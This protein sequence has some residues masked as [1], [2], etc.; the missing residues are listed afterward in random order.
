[1]LL[2]LMCILGQIIDLHHL[3]HHP[4]VERESSSAVIQVFVYTIRQQL[5]DLEL[6]ITAIEK[7]DL[8]PS[9]EEDERMLVL[10][11]R[12]ILSLYARF[13]YHVLH[14]LPGT[15][16]DK[17]NLIENNFYIHSSHF[18]ASLEHSIVSADILEEIMT[19]DQ[20]MAFKLVFLGYSHFMRQHFPSP[21]PR[22]TNRPPLHRF[23]LP[24]KLM[25]VF[26]KRQTA[27]IMRSICVRCGGCS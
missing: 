9:A 2:P 12:R 26:T 13:L 22:N 23:L 21:Q 6:S 16:W 7:C 20:E 17:L 27:F 5:Q 4:R 15:E 14:A 1:M 18:N 3:S 24:V 19:L 11:Y 25:Y 8:S 10:R